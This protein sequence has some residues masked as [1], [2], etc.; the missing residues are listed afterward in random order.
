MRNSIRRSPLLTISSLKNF[1]LQR[2]NVVIAACIGLLDSWIYPALAPSF[3]GIS[4]PWSMSPSCVLILGCMH[5]SNCWRL[6]IA[7]EVSADEMADIKDLPRLSL[8]RVSRSLALM[9]LQN[10]GFLQCCPGGEG[11]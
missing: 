2:S 11:V 10:T 4:N 7:D 9:V 3:R 5:H 6:S 1:P 8:I